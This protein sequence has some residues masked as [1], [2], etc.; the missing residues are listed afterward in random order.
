MQLPD[1][2]VEHDAESV[3][4]AKHERPFRS[5]HIVYTN[6]A[7]DTYVLS[8]S[9]TSIS[10][11]T[12]CVAR[13]F[14]RTGKKLNDSKC[15]VLCSGEPEVGDEARIR[16]WGPKDLELYESGVQPAR[17]HTTDGTDTKFL[18]R[19]REMTVLGSCVVLRHRDSATAAFNHRCKAAWRAWHVLADQ[20]TSRATP[21]KLRISLLDTTVM[22]SL[23]CGVWRQWTWARKSVKI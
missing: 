18:K 5:S 22:A 19:V 20:L 7:D 9:T 8:A 17:L 14:A 3:E 15:D 12:A 13:E 4:S 11:S 1:P 23:F 21:L 2:T 6:F 16:A 10:Y